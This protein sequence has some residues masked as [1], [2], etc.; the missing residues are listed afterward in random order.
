[1]LIFVSI[2]FLL[3]APAAHSTTLHEAPSLCACSRFSDSLI[4]VDFYQSTDGPNWTNSW[5]LQK[6]MT[7]WNGVSLN[8]N[9]CVQNVILINNKLKGFLPGSLGFLSDLKIF[10]LFGNEVAGPIP[11]QMGML[12]QL[13]EL[14]LE[15]NLLSGAIPAELSQ[16]SSLK[17]LSL[18]KNQLEGG[19]P[20]SLS[21]L[22]NLVV[23]NVSYNKLT[24]VIPPTF[25]QLS[26]LNILDL[27]HNELSGNVPFALGQMLELREIY[28]QENLFSGAF[29]PNM[30]Q[31]T[32]LIH[33]WAYNNDFSGRVPDFTAAPLNSLRIENNS[34]TE[35]PD[36]SVVSTWGNSFPFG[37]VIYGNKLTFEDLIPL[38]AIHR[39]Y[40][41]QFAPQ[42]PVKLNP[43]IFAASGS[44]YII[45]TGVDP[46]LTE[47]NYKWFKDSSLVF[48][49]NK[50]TYEIIQASSLDEGYYSGRI[51][52]PAIPSFEIAID[53]FRVVVYDPQKCDKPL[54]GKRCESALAFCST[55]SL[56]NYCGTLGVIDTSIHYFLCDSNVQ[57]LNPRCLSFVAPSDSIV[58]EILPVDCPGI[59]ENGVVYKGMQVA[60]WKSCLQPGDSVLLCKTECTNGT[61]TIG[62]KLFER[63]STYTLIITGCHGDNCSYLVRVLAGKERFN[64]DAP[65]PIIGDL[66]LCPGPEE[67]IYSIRSIAGAAAY[68]W[69]FADTLFGLT[70]DSFIVLKNLN[71]GMHN[72]RV[73]AMNAC[74]TTA[75]SQLWLDVSPKLNLL[76]AQLSRIKTD[77]AFQIMFTI[78]GGAAPYLVTKGRGKLDNGT[79][80]FVSD[81]LLCKSGYEFEITDANQCT[82]VYKGYEKCDCNSQA[83]AMPQ[84]TIQVCEGQSFSVQHL[85]MEV[86][87]PQD[88]A[89]YLIFTDPLDPVHSIVKSNSIGLFTFDPSR[90]KLNTWFYISRVAGRRNANGEINYLHPCLSISNFQVLIFRARPLVSAGPDLKVCGY[91]AALSSFGS[92]TKAIWK[93]TSGPGNVL[94]SDS[95]NSQTNVRVDSFG[96]YT[97]TVEV[98]NGYCTSKDDI[99][100][101]FVDNLKPDIAGFLFVC[102]GQQTNLDAGTF[103]KYAWSTGDSTQQIRVSTPGTYCVTVTDNSGC[104]GT[105]CVVVEPS[106][107]P[108]VGMF[109]PS[110]LCTGDQAQVSLNASFLK[111]HW[112]TQD[113]TSKI[114]VDTGGTYCVTVTGFNGCTATDCIDII[115]KSRSYFHFYDT[116]CYGESYTLAN[117]S[118]DKPGLYQVILENTSANSCDSVIFLHLQWTDQIILNDTIILSDNGTGTGALSVVT[119]GGRKPYKYLWSNG[120]RTSTITNLKAGN[121]IL[122]VTDADNCNAAFSLNVPMSTGQQE[123]EAEN[124]RPFVIFPNPSVSGNALYYILNH[125]LSKRFYMELITLDGRSLI[126]PQLYSCD[127]GKAAAIDWKLSQGVY[128]VKI[129]T[130]DGGKHMIR[131][132]IF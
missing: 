36:Y 35:I 111:Y 98:N 28:L 97:F 110:T 24:G 41:Y 124:S 77:S 126:P 20:Y 34:F 55:S 85:G 75:F 46:G 30:S 91:D 86:L 121:Y 53:S 23:L 29:P 116:A 96:T 58:I 45:Q 106:N 128:L 1:M 130:E 103:S 107:A 52:N 61:I 131:L 33:F 37:I 48:I 7:Q 56:H 117:N 69:Y 13:E 9:G 120:N 39:R 95:L 51:T 87:D 125:S 81:T 40:N 70:T 31:L 132:I 66:K 64:L 79:G 100:V 65:G 80:L 38:T 19:L 109:A 16:C 74:D 62:G 101:S 82:I 71:S 4:L 127:P 26:K 89:V 10:Y 129:K 90:F 123:T 122:I 108:R 92:F 88:L 17:Y 104:T 105:N 5:D 63:G 99:K 60:I 32:K 2:L 22:S 50:N 76:N 73:Q 18:A 42:D 54:A 6:P 21:N 57:V 15:D 12:G 47:N 72:L 84:D 25:G 115:P 94:F 44:N 3:W 114:T 93:K 119:G 68:R 14:V 118:F 102:Q 8:P 11:S 113:T 59:T 83:G 112:N 49:S 67:H 78:S 43:L 27:N